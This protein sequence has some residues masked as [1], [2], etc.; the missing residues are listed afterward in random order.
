MVQTPLGEVVGGLK[1]NWDQIGTRQL[2]TAKALRSAIQLKLDDS[3]RRESEAAKL[4]TIGKSCDNDPRRTTQY[5]GTS[6]ATLGR[7]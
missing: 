7:L 6:T 5:C 1:I 4:E 3:I 2:A